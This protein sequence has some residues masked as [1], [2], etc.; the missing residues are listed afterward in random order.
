MNP[1]LVVE[2]NCNV[3]TNEMIINNNIVRKKITLNLLKFNLTELGILSCNP[4]AIEYIHNNN[5]PPNKTE[6]IGII[7]LDIVVEGNG[8]NTHSNKIGSPTISMKIT[9]DLVCNTFLIIHF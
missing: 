9:Q 2:C 5:P 8:G 4:E 3:I 1:K 6:I 7:I